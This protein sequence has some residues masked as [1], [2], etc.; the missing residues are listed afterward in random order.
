MVNF[1]RFDNKNRP[2]RFVLRWR[3]RALGYEGY[4]TRNLDN[5]N[6]YRKNPAAESEATEKVRITEKVQSLKKLKRLY[7]FSFIIKVSQ[8]AGERMIRQQ[9]TLMLSPYA[10]LYNIVVPKRQYAASDQQT[11]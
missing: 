7:L 9:Q 11:G 4:N 2:P 1:S 8:R 10:D 3:S 6:A 5:S